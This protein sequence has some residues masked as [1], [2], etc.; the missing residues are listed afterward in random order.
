MLLTRLEALRLESARVCVLPPTVLPTALKELSF[1]VAARLVEPPARGA[2]RHRGR[3]GAA[4]LDSPAAGARRRRRRRHRALLC[5][6]P[7][8]SASAPRCASSRFASP[9]QCA[10]A[11]PQRLLLGVLAYFA[12]TATQ[13]TGDLDALPFLG[14]LLR[15]RGA[16]LRERRRATPTATRA[17]T[18]RC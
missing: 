10:R 9:C 6:S 11:S 17:S 2:R 8:T 5:T 18:S 3:V 15:A 7:R 13:A 12:R 4:P 1:C 14:E 16:A